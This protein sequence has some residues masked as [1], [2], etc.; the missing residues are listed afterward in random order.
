M[1]D[2]TQQNNSCRSYGDRVETFNYIK[3]ECNKKNIKLDTTGWRKGS[4][5]NCARNVNFII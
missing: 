3:C 4:T 1:I 5:G 2:K